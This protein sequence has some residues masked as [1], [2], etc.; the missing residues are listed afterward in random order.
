[1][2]NKWKQNLAM[3]WLSQ[4]FV[5]AG[6]D[7]MNPFISLFLKDGLNI[8]DPER[9]ALYVSLYNIFS[10]VGYGI[11]NPLWG[12]LG[13]KYGMRMM[14][15]RGTFLTAIFWP[16]MAYVQHPIMLVILRFVTAFFAGT[17]AASQMMIARTAPFERQGFAQGVLTSAIW[18]GSIL[19]NILGGL[20]IDHYD[21]RIAFWLCGIMYFIAGIFIIF[22][23]DKGNAAPQLNKNVD[24]SKDGKIPSLPSIIWLIIGMFLLHGLIRRIDLPYIALRVE[25]IVSSKPAYWTGIISSIVGIG[26]ILSGVACG[27]IVDK[28]SAKKLVMPI[29]ISISVLALFQGI[30]RNLFFFATTRTLYFFLAGFIQPMLQKLLSYRTPRD[31]RGLAFGLST[32]AFSIGGIFASTIGGTLMGQWGICGVFIGTGIITLISYPIFQ[33]GVNKTN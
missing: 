29:L 8:T 30:G 7:A 11:S 3:L 24:I 26:S 22:T 14:L 9:L 2:N 21:Y 15:L 25:Q 13:D 18:G 27:L 32:T 5:M 1:M 19:G 16:M 6:Y 31:K 17:T 20:V 12:W 10:F 28:I 4:L 33:L 23:F